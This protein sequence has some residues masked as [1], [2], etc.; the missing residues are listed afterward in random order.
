MRSL[1]QPDGTET[2]VIVAANFTGEAIRRLSEHFPLAHFFSRPGAIVPE[3]RT[4]GVE[5]STGDIIALIEDHCTVDENWSH[6]IVQAHKS[7]SVVGGCVDNSDD[8]SALD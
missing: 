7:H 6:E 1:R 5:Q 3:L 8:Q 2:E 4:C